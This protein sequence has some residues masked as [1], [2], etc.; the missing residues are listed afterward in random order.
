M[1]ASPNPMTAV[2]GDDPAA[3]SA[4]HD[5][6]GCSDIAQ[7]SARSHDGDAGHQASLRHLADMPGRLARLA[8]TQGQR[9]I[10]MKTLELAGHIDVDD[11]AIGHD[12]VHGRHAVADHR[13]ATGANRSRKPVVPQLAGSR[14]ASSRVLAYPCIDLGRGNAW[15]DTVAHPRQRRRR[16]LAGLS[17][18]LDLACTENGYSHGKT[19]RRPRRAVQYLL[20]MDAVES[21]KSCYETG[22]SLLQLESLVAVAEEGQLAR[23]AKRLH[24]TQPPLTRRIRSLEDE[25]GV[26]LF[27]RTA[28]G[29]RL[30]P[31]GHNLVEHARDILARVESARRSVQ[32]S[33]GSPRTTSRPPGSPARL[34]APYEGG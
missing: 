5:L 12:V 15:F 20:G 2:V 9:R 27:D 23:A 6:D 29:M 31:E 14:A 1:H 25:L 7:S 8:D 4:S 32:T 33:G 11:V 18:A 22:V 10:A 30:R 24:V 26:Q 3:F 21:A 17:H 13:I 16:H 28:K 34:P 19:V